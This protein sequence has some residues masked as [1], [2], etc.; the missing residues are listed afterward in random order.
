MLQMAI[1]AWLLS[2]Q[3]AVMRSWGMWEMDTGPFVPGGK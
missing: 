3:N 1:K 2:A